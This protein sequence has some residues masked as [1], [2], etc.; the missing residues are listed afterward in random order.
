M[1]L[2]IIQMPINCN[3]KVGRNGKVIDKIAI[4]HAAGTGSLETIQTIFNTFGR[5]A[6]AHYAVRCQDIA[7][8]LEEEHTAWA[9]SNREINESAVSIE[10][11]NSAKEPDWPV[12]QTTYE[13]L[14]KL[15]F[16]IAQRLYLF[17]LIPGYNL[18][19]HSMFVETV[20]PGPWLLDRM[21]DLAYRVNGIA[22]D[23]TRLGYLI[24]TVKDY[25]LESFYRVRNEYNDPSSQQGAFSEYRNA[26]LLCDVLNENAQKPTWFIYNQDNTKLYPN[27]AKK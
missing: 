2:K 14:I 15:V 25:R 26:Q 4:H 5:N 18:V 12:A 19:W 10:V 27:G 22:N 7:Q 23:A 1:E 8:Y 11:V 21:Q 9:N 17:P 6:S 3:Y 16:E 20:C 24:E 13:T